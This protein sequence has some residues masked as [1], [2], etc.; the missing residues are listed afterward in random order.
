MRADK[1]LEEWKQEVY[2]G[3]NLKEARKP[4]HPADVKT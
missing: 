1:A 2:A 3:V 4:V